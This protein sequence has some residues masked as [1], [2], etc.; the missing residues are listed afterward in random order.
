MRATSC[1]S[2]PATGSLL[3]RAVSTADPF[4]ESSRSRPLPD[5]A[6]VLMSL[7]PSLSECA[8]SPL[9]GE[10]GFVSL[11]SVHLYSLLPEDKK[12]TSNG[13]HL[14]LTKLLIRRKETSVALINSLPSYYAIRNS[15]LQTKSR[16]KTSTNDWVLRS[17]PINNL[18]RVFARH[19]HILAPKHLKGSAGDHR[20]KGI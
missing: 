14:S 4:L 5:C 15:D 3:I 20:R 10:V 9:Q 18:G 19:S 17:F 1:I 6:D 8:V 16:R 2:C 7:L 11:H 12:T 13:V